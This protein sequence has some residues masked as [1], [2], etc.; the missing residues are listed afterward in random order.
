MQPF[1][2]ADS[3]GADRTEVL[4]L[5]VQAA[6]LGALYQNWQVLCPN[7]RVPHSEAATLTEVPPR[8]HCD[9]CAVD[10]DSD[11]AQNVELRYSVHPSIRPAKDEVHCIGGPANSPH[12]WLQ[13]Y[14]LPGTE[15]AVSV[16]L[17]REPFRVR[18]L[19]VNLTCP[20]DPAPGGP[21]DV[22][23]TYR[24][25]GWYQM[26]QQFSPGAVTVRLRNETA[27]VL[28][29]VIEQLHWDTRALTAAQVMTLPEFRVLAGVG[30]GQG[31]SSHP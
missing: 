12:V 11:L 2:L 18:A 26:R 24:D 17:P 5:L 29:A 8:V 23:F 13:Q 16:T 25:D 7:C 14:L 4:R 15:R 1:A 28:V 9:A 19:R 10:Y 31:T 21:S 22:V 30:P 27:R 20:L 3:W 6:R